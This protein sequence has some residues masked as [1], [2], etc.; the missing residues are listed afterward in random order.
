MHTCVNKC[1]HGQSSINAMF[2][3]QPKTNSDC[4][5]DFN[6]YH[7]ISSY[8]KMDWKIKDCIDIRIEIT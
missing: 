7:T 2:K 4:R 8:L 6:V 1:V 3:K 5:R